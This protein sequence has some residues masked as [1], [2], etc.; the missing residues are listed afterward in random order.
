MNEAW[1]DH[2]DMEHTWVDLDSDERAARTPTVADLRNSIKDLS[3]KNGFSEEARS[4]GIRH[5]LGSINTPDV[6]VQMPYVVAH[7]REN[8]VREERRQRLLGHM[9]KIAASE[10]YFMEKEGL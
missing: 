5:V 6:D 4:I 8:D 1:D 9:H 10:P 7:E 2:A 3:T